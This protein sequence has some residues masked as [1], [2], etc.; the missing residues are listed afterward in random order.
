MPVETRPARSTGAESESGSLS[1]RGDP[2]LAAEKR[3]PRV[4]QRVR[5]SGCSQPAPSS[6]QTRNGQNSGFCLGIGFCRAGPR[7]R[8]GDNS[9]A[10]GTSSPRGPWAAAAPQTEPNRA[11]PGGRQDYTSRAAP[12]AGGLPG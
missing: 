10:G 1:Q 2:L 11:G 6:A 3:F 4:S 12:A 8:S 7:T 5:A 9:S